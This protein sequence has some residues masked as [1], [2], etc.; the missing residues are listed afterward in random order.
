MARVEVALGDTVVAARDITGSCAH[1]DFAACPLA[2]RSSLSVDTRAVADG[3]HPLTLRV[4]DAAG[5][6]HVEEVRTVD[7]RNNDDVPPPGRE[8]ALEHVLGALLSARFAT[9][10]RTSLTVP[11]GRHVS[12]RGRLTGAG[13][14]GIGG[15]PI[16]VFER[17]TGAPEV[18]LGSART[19]ADGTFSYT[20]EGRQPSR[21]VRLAYG[22]TSAPL[23]RV[24]VRA[25]STLKASLHGTIVR[26][27]GRVL[28]QPLPKRGTPVILQGN[29][30]GYTWTPFANLRTD[31]RGRFAGRYR[32]PVR[33]PG[34][35][36]QIRV[37]VPTQRG[38][39]YLGYTGRP[40]VLTVR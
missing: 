36:L 15:A 10:S 37:R 14:S 11:F 2:D 30:P 18:A 22:A 33:R 32:L 25:A 16:D 5:N 35:K 4:I 1:A 3:S 12:I 28:S 29:A 13:R 38:Y 31:R 24:R 8:N 26:F 23:L 40:V 27:S 9:S 19:R 34:V 39:P 7:V 17:A 20:L 21:S 6:R